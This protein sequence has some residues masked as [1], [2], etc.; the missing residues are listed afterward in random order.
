[1]I[2]SRPLFR[3]PGMAFGKSRAAREQRQTLVPKAAA[4]IAGV[5]DQ[6]LAF[7]VCEPGVRSALPTTTPVERL[8]VR[9]RRWLPPITCLSSPGIAARLSLTVCNA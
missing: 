8:L 1:M 2:R 9:L 5:L 6:S 3:L 7:V 4:K